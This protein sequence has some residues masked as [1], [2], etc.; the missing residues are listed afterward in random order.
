M[1]EDVNGDAKETKIQKLLHR[2]LNDKQRGCSEILSD[3]LRLLEEVEKE[4]RE[5]TVEFARRLANAHSG[6]EGFVKVMEE[7]ARRGVKAVRREVERANE[8]TAKALSELTEGKVIVTISRSGIVERALRLG[9]PAKV[10]ILISRPG[11]EGRLTLER[12]KEF[13]DVEL[14]EDAEM[15][16][17]VKKSGLVVCGADAISKLGFVNKVGTLPLMLTAKYFGVKRF[18]ASPLYKLVSS[19]NAVHPFEFVESKLA[20]LLTEKGFTEWEGL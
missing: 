6:M 18:V 9:R 16:A 19:I 3:S 11:E 7:V 15:G 1:S 10:Y 2:L 20:E 14:V 4:S 12:L 8:E 5:R 17:F 13:I